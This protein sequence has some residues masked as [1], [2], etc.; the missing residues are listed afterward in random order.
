MSRQCQWLQGLI[1]FC[2]LILI[3][4]AFSQS[5]A[6]AVGVVVGREFHCTMFTAKF[7]NLLHTICLELLFNAGVIIRNIQKLMVLKVHSKV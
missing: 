2:V 7:W 5:A 6:A 1:S 3:L 4:I